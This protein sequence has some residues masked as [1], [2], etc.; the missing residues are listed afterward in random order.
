MKEHDQHYR[1]ESD[2][3]TQERLTSFGGDQYTSSGGDSMPDGSSGTFDAE[4]RPTEKDVNKR[5]NLQGEVQPQQPQQKSE[6]QFLGK[7]PL[8]AQQNEQAGKVLNEEDIVDPSGETYK[9][10]TD[11]YGGLKVNCVEALADEIMRTEPL[12][13]FKK[14]GRYPLIDKKGNFRPENFLRWVRHWMIYWHKD[15]PDEEYNYGQK[16][17]LLRDYNPISL[18]AMIS[19]PDR[20]FRSWKS[21]EVN[22]HKVHYVYYDL[23]EQ[24]KKEL[25]LF[26]ASRSFD[27]NYRKIMG[28][29]TEL[30]K[31]IQQLYANNTF[32]KTVWEGKS[33]LYHILTLP[34]I[35]VDAK[36][37]GNKEKEEKQDSRVGEALNTAFLTYYNLSD[38]EELEKLLGKDSP[39]L[40]PRRIKQKLMEMAD[41]EGL[42]D[43]WKTYVD[44][45]DLKKLDSGDPQDLI[46]FINIFNLATKPI[47]II[48]AVRSLIRE[49]IAEKFNLY[50]FDENGNPIMEDTFIYDPETGQKTEVKK[51]KKKID[52]TVAEYAEI[53][54]LSM[55]RWTGAAARNDTAAVGYDA[56][57]KVQVTDD[58]R[59]KQL[60]YSRSGAFGNP[61]TIHMLKQLG[62]DFFTATNVESFEPYDEK[63]HLRK[64]MTLKVLE[65]MQSVAGNEKAYKSVASQLVFPE[66][67]MRSFANDHVSRTFEIFHQIIEAEEIRIDKFT[68]F[69]YGRGITFDR[70]AFEEAV[71]EKF[72]K[73]MRY[74]WSTYAQINFAQRVRAMDQDGNYKEMY[75]AEAMFGREIL[76]IPEFWVKD[77]N[78]RKIPIDA[79]NWHEK[80][81]WEYLNTRNAKVALWRQVALGRLAAELYAHRDKY[82]KDPYYGIA[83]YEQVIGALEE[84]PASVMG[85]EFDL[86]SA[87]ESGRFFT[88]RDIEWLRKKSNTTR[89]QLFGKQA[90]KDMFLGL[91]RG[92]FTA[93]KDTIK[94]SVKI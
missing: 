33:A 28:S 86:R 58:Y 4:Q 72:F 93:F 59:M 64:K 76:D 19:N 35:F 23:V 43:Q 10:E 51:G 69:D 47:R 65:E 18:S 34:D 49:S 60:A 52:S 84:L 63:G 77:K 56:W 40:D 82:S 53:F 87:K 92:F 8:D 29:D 26:A 71:K 12:P 46:E 89:A 50:E 42:L 36:V 2:F 21:K 22:G 73:P 94:S 90:I 30:P 68:H 48:N 44:P 78:K 17:G 25:W 81:D 13:E 62:R 67:T 91:S 32:T 16:I 39:L 74:A 15:S 41:S 24:I 7:N 3:S 45:A 1:N 75:L 38:H 54:A 55:A 31:I 80:I 37:S 85:D 66:N 88:K 9:K 83:F 70:K 57:T 61:Y 5:S 14:D 79:P 27:I 20:F 11:P 6:N